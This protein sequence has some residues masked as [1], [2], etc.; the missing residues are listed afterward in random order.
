MITD[1]TAEEFE[2]LDMLQVWVRQRITEGWE[3]QGG[4]SAYSHTYTNAYD[5]NVSDTWFAQAMVKVTK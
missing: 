2:S 4:I 5:V 3:P 1:Y